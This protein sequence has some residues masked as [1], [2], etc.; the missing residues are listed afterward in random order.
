MPARHPVDPEEPNRALGFSTLV[1]GL[2]ESYR[3]P[4]PLSK[5]MPS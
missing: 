4:I 3:V 5:V 2:Y 1:T